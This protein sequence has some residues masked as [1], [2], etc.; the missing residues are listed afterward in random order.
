MQLNAPTPISRKL[1]IVFIVFLVFGCKSSGGLLPFIYILVAIFL[2][3]N[4]ISF[5]KKFLS[6]RISP[7]ILTSLIWVNKYG[8]VVKNTLYP[9]MQVFIPKSGHGMCLT[10]SRIPVHH[11][12]VFLL[13]LQSV[14]RISQCCMAV[15]NP[16]DRLGF[17]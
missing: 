1:R 9:S 8:A 7:G 15:R 3:R 16:N 5:A 12:I 10:S 14:I 4:Y 17:N 6:R 11:N 2:L 13:Y